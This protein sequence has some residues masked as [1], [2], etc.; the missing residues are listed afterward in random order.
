MHKWEHVERYS[1]RLL[2]E[3]DAH[4]QRGAAGFGELLSS[5]LSEG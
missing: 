2:T 4:L 1:S 5:T 3:V